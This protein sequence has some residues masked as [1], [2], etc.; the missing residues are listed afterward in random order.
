MHGRLSAATGD[1]ADLLCRE[2][3]TADP[4]DVHL[5]I[6][7]FD[8][9]ADLRHASDSQHR[10]ARRVR[11]I[12]VQSTMGCRFRDGGPSVRVGGKAPC[13]LGNV[14][15]GRQR[16]SRQYPPAKILRGGVSA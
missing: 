11:E 14:R 1:P 5:A 4:L 7:R 8:I 12:E 9:D 15:I 3:A 13:A 16:D 10:H 6:H 2:D